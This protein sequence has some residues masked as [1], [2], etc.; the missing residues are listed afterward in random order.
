MSSA[1]ALY[2]ERISQLFN[3]APIRLV[4]P[5]EYP[6]IT[7]HFGR[8]PL[9]YGRFGLP[10]HEGIDIQAPHGS[11]IFACADGEVYLVESS[12][13]G[14]YGNQVRIKH[15]DG[16]ATVYAHLLKPMVCTGDIVV[17]GQVIG[18]ADNTGNSS[19][20]H[21]HLTLKLEGATAAGR[22]GSAVI[23]QNWAKSGNVRRR[24]VDAQGRDC[25]LRG[26]RYSFV[27]MMIH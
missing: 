9:Y 16:Y 14:N 18:L 1:L 4:W 15:R 20:D 10:G 21:L 7:Q 19:G 11:K 24:R 8:N 26:D 17:A 25:E 23:G 5:T 27:P 12:G 6:V 2:F 13:K 22:A 3:P